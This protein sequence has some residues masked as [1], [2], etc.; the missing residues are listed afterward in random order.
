M[1][2]L[3]LLLLLLF[4]CLFLQVLEGCVCVNPG[5]LTKGSSGG[6]FAKITVSEQFQIKENYS[7][8]IGVQIV[9]I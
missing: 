7:S 6:T 8:D 3:L 1:L 4:I 2:L 5:H 9:H